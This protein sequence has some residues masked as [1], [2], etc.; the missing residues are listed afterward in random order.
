MNIT[1]WINNSFLL[2]L[3][4]KELKEIRIVGVN[5]PVPL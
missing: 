4:N 1:E 5:V 3:E 2:T